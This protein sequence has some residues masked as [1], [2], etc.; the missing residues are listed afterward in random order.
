MVSSC[1]Q[2]WMLGA[3]NQHLAES[4]E[5]LADVQTLLEEFKSVFQI[6]ENLPPPRG[7]DHHIH[8]LPNATPVN[9][10]PYR[11]PHYKKTEMEKMVR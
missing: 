8:L 11:Y 6:P 9:V 5:V 7:F 10:R 1:L 4:G 3:N 2:L